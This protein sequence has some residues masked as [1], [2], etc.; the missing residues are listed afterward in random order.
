MKNISRYLVAATAVLVLS[1]GGAHADLFEELPDFPRWYFSPGIGMMIYEGN[2]PVMGGLRT[3][4]HTLEGM[5]L[6]LR[7]GYHYSE[8]W[9]LEGGLLIVPRLTENYIGITAPRSEIEAQD[10]M[11]R[12]K[13]GYTEDENGIIRGRISAVR[14]NPHF[15]ET[16]MSTLYGDALFHFTRWE[17]LDPYLAGGLGLIV[18]GEDLLKSERNYDFML[19]GGCGV[20]YHI[21]D[22]WALRADWRLLITTDSTEF[23][24]QADAGVVWTWGA[25]IPPDFSAAGGPVIDDVLAM[26]PKPD[27][28]L[29]LHFDYDQAVIKP[30]Y[31]E[32]LDEVAEALRQRPGT[33]A[34]IEGHADQLRR[35]SARYNK[36]LSQRR[37]ESVK[38][39]L[40]SR[41]GI[42]AE[43]LTPIGHGFERPK[44]TPNLET[45][46]PENRR[47]EIYIQDDARMAGQ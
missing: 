13:P 45:G 28:E 7:M 14:K 22:E 31:F 25:R 30:E 39:Y 4:G 12:L 24:T 43:R 37:A 27:F 21:N 6:N 11:R 38:D 32:L 26:R 23:N 9:S 1:G 29:Y 36:R 3:G 10:N 5:M 34:T 44:V 19:R 16:W 46:T 35:S 33:T 20:K 2:E 47:V 41:A 18:Y 42:R 15:G 8:W 40:V 17:R